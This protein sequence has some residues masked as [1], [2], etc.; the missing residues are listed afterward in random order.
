MICTHNWGHCLEFSSVALAS[1]I[2]YSFYEDS[3]VLTIAENQRRG[4]VWPPAA[5]AESSVLIT[6][7]PCASLCEKARW[8][9]AGDI[10]QT[11]FASLW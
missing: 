9:R 7:A 2:P 5:M 3:R 11:G 4:R 6:F 10:I 1:G 8:L